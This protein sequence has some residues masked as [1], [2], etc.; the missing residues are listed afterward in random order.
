M[1]TPPFLWLLFLIPL[2]FFIAGVFF[3]IRVYTRIYK[4]IRSDPD[5]ALDSILSLAGKVGIDITDVIKLRNSV[6]GEKLGESDIIERR[7]YRRKIIEYTVLLCRAEGE[8][9]MVLR[10]TDKVDS[11]RLT[12]LFSSD[13]DVIY[14]PLKQTVCREL[15]NILG[16]NEEA[17][18]S[19]AAEG[20]IVFKS[21]RT[22]KT[23]YVDRLK[24]I[25]VRWFTFKTLR[26]F[27]IIDDVTKSV[28]LGS[29]KQ[30][31]WFQRISAYIGKEND[32]ILLILKIRSK[33]IVKGYRIK[34]L[35]PA[36][37]NYTLYYPFGTSGREF[38]RSAFNTCS[39]SVRQNSAPELFR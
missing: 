16:A 17:F 21:S 8:K 35:S 25:F 7:K 28:Q 36:V 38:L 5:E 34:F 29:G 1:N 39:I 32:E 22:T 31:F 13:V 37:F 2:L 26:Y 4:K 19:K 24:S 15:A 6:I 14:C 33:L 11:P 30:A 10:I 20:E 3:F 23:N 9:Q 27:G 12:D 18:L